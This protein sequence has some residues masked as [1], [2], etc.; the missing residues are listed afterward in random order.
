MASLKNT[1][2]LAEKIRFAGPSNIYVAGLCLCDG[3]IVGHKIYNKILK[4]DNCYNDFLLGFGGQACLDFYNTTNKWLESHPGFSGFA[5]ASQQG[6]R[7]NYAFGF[8]D[9]IKDKLVF[10]AFELQNTTQQSFYFYGENI[11]RYV[12]AASVKGAEQFRLKTN[13]IEIQDNGSY[14][15]CP[16]IS[17]E[18]IPG[19][20]YDILNSLD[21]PN[22]PIYNSIKEMNGEFKI[23][24]FGVNPAYQKIYIV[25]EDNTNLDLLVDSVIELRKTFK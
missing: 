15:F 10:R 3:K 1:K 7:H 22:R 23:V 16:K 21:E 20:E 24:N 19:I 4:K 5:V 25:S 2:Q 13:L 11:Y 17:R 12:D 9:L 8:K 6:K 18:T 14:C